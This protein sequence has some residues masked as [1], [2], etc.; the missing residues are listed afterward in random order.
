MDFAAGS[1]E[2]RFEDALK[3][4]AR[5]HDVAALRIYDKRETE[6]P[7]VGMAEMTDAET[8]RTIFVDT[9]RR[10]IR[11]TYG[12]WWRTRTERLDKTFSRLRVDAVNI[13]TG[14]DYI[15]PLMKLFKQRN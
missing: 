6:L 7:A 1:A 15:K 9:S 12:E 11:N 14:E 10:K 13:N 2:P 4:A 8:G 3:I 5:K